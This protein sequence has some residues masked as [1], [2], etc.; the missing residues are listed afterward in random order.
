MME[1]YYHI[2]LKRAGAGVAR[3]NRK[4]NRKAGMRCAWVW[5]EVYA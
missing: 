1:V 3:R 5:L 4:W 2:K